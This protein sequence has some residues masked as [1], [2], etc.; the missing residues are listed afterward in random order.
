MG[1]AALGSDEG[2]DS[3]GDFRLV[4]CW[5]RLFVYERGASSKEQKLVQTVVLRSA[6]LG[7][8]KVA[9]EHMFRIQTPVRAYVRQALVLPTSVV[10]H[11][12]RITQ[13]L[14]TAFR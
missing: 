7:L 8:Y 12:L 3:F 4:L 10:F 6:I 14:I 5:N 13:P 2:Q 1:A 11:I 9:D